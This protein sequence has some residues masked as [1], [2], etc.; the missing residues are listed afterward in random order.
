M[1][2]SVLEDGSGAVASANYGLDSI[3]LP[4]GD[5]IECN[6]VSLAYDGG[7][8][9]AEVAVANEYTFVYA[10]SDGEVYR[11]SVE[12]PIPARITYPQRGD[13]I[14]RSEGFTARWE[15]KDTHSETT[16]ALLVRPGA[17]CRTFSNSCS[18]CPPAPLM[19]KAS[20]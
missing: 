17:S 12:S 8:Y 4:T 18:V 15:R 13:T 19:A 20:A 3:Q 10:R 16:Y 14:T 6:G 5:G 11:G 7:S 1:R 9:R 2:F